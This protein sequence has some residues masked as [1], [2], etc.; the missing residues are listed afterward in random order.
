MGKEI[1]NYK[2]VVPVIVVCLLVIMFIQA[3]LSLRLKSLTFDETSH[4]PAG[5]S[6]LKTG[7]Y[8]INLEQPPLI[9]LLAGFPL[10]FMKLNLPLYS[11]YWKE[12]SQYQ[13]GKFFI[14]YSGNNA[15]RIIFWGRIP[16]VLLAVLL[17]YFIFIW[18]ERLYGAGAG[19][20]ALFFYV[21]SPNMLAYSRL[22]VMDFGLGCFMLMACYQLWRYLE[23]PSPGGLALA[24]V[25][26][27][28]ALVTKF[29]AVMLLPV[30]LVMAVY[31]VFIDKRGMKVIT[32]GNDTPD[33][34]SGILFIVS[35]FL[36]I[37]VI[38]I[39]II[40]LVYGLKGD[41]L[42]MYKKGLDMIYYNQEQSYKFYMNGKFSPEPWW[43]YYLFAFL[44]KTP[45]P[46]LIMIIFAAVLL[47]KQKHDLYREMW[48]LLPVLI[49]L[50]TSFFDARNLG[51]RR[52]LPVYPFLFVFIGK[53][54]SG[55]EP[56]LFPV[57]KNTRNVII[58]V[59]CVWY[60]I[61]SVGIYPDYLTYFNVLAGGAKNGINYLDDSNIDWGQD[62]KR[63]KT[64]MDKNNIPQVKL[65]YFG[66]SDEKYYKINSVPLENSELVNGPRPGNYYAMSAHFLA[67]LKLAVIEGSVKVDWLK[68]YEPVDVIGN[69]IYIYK[70]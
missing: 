7:D 61:L 10:L 65:K 50:F 3:V 42:G 64:Y 69:T 17:G 2:K 39:V 51:L 34:T 1:I 29:S 37:S 67:R 58:G 56:W 23:K 36:V 63:L 53:V 35:G 19:L 62:L 22:V 44:V 68:E 47:K 8:R 4:L 9:K 32:P 33:I 66:T 49:I 26:T 41:A 59:L 70:F 54:A 52:I 21:F 24:G 48:L 25:F 5:Y 18:T 38:S 60:I 46:T 28:L 57:K 13:F 31:R 27:G 16:M 15:E 14:F 45:V 6:Y 55:K 11:N 40:Y 30:F 43:Y 20:F 12:N